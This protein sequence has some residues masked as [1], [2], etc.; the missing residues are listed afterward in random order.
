[1]IFLGNTA[2]DCTLISFSSPSI[3]DTVVGPN[4]SCSATYA[5]RRP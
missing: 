1:M 4:A 5:E 2:L 3:P